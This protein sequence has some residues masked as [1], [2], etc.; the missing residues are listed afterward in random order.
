MS[1]PD[2]AVKVLPTIGFTVVPVL[3][4]PGGQLVMDTNDILDWLD[5]H[6]QE[7]D[8]LPK[9]PILKFLERLIGAFAS[10]AMLPLTMHYRWSFLA[11]QESFL[12]AEFGR[13]INGLPDKQQ[14]YELASQAMDWMNSYLPALAVT[15]QTIPTLEAWYMDLLDLLDDLFIKHPYF[16]GGLPSRADFGFNGAAICAFG[17]GSGAR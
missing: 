7:P 13:S 3:E 2:F 5:E 10:E 16:L 15:A 12:R 1:H 6:Y 14:S 11:R 17:A 4:T 8:L 9:N